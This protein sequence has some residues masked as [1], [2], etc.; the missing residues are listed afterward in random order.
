MDDETPTEAPEAPESSSPDS[1]LSQIREEVS[2][3]TETEES[4]AP[5]EEAPAWDPET[6]KDHE[7]FKTWRDRE[8][9]THRR[10]AHIE[11]QQREAGRR[12]EVADVLR[13]VDAGI[14]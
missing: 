9:K 1:A 7:E 6:W 5:K 2:T 13:Q 4:A 8:I 11:G 12:Q 14:A 3:A 10:E